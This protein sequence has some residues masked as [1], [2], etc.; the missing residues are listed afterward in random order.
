MD[1]NNFSMRVDDIFQAGGRGCIVATGVVEKG[2]IR[3]KDTV[4]T[5]PEGSDKPSMPGAIV[6]D[7][8]NREDQRHHL[9]EAKE[10][11]EIAIMLQFFSVQIGDVLTTSK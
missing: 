11:D 2:S 7:I 8:V 3:K 10:G 9:A 1:E 4:R 6:I 5:I